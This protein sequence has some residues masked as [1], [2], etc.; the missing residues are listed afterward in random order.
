MGDALVPYEYGGRL[1]YKDYTMTDWVADDDDDLVAN[2]QYSNGA[3]YSGSQLGSPDYSMK[4][5]GCTYIH[6]QVGTGSSRQIIL[7][8]MHNPNKANYSISFN[9]GG[10]G[11]AYNSSGTIYSSAKTFILED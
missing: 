6:A 3:E 2:N 5:K 10:I 9:Y 1:W 7:S 11:I 4:L 8:Y